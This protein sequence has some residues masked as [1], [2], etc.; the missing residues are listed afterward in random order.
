ML[1]PKLIRQDPERVRTGIRNRGGRYLPALEELITLDAEYRKKLAQ[2]EELRG[3]RNAQSKKIG[4][5]MAAKDLAAAEALKAEV[6]KLKA[7]LEAGE[8]VLKPMT[9]AARVSAMGLPNPPHESVP[10]GKGPEDNRVVRGGTQPPEPAFKARDHHSVGE[11]LGIIDFAAAVKLSGS[12]FT[13][14]RGAGAKLER[15]LISFM[16]ERHLAKGYEEIWPPYLV[17]REIAEGTGQLPKF[18]PDL[19][20]TTTGEDEGDKELFLI[21][22][23]EVPLTNLVREQILNES[24]LPLKFAA[25]TPCF[26]LEAGSYGKDVRGLIRVHQFDK[27]ELVWITKPE[28]SQNALEGLTAD[29]EGVLTALGI[30]HRV[31]ALCTGDMGFSAAKTYDLEVWMPGEGKWREISSCSDCGDFQARRMEAR[32]RR[33]AQGDPEFV[34]T[35]NGSGVAVGRLFAAVLENCQQADGSVKIPPALVPHFGAESIKPK[36]A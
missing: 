30:P 4:A 6:S 21:P 36:A 24:V 18:E 17:K 8:A 10:L 32:F 7:E 25:F 2:V 9:E 16:L 26:R 20:K 1:D 11:K 15:A 3:K 19:Y 14:L 23:A 22:T 31:V 5:A 28:D 34:H 35:L 13:L 12:R 27:V 33:G 29:A